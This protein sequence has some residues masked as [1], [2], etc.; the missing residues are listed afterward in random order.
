M[1][2]PE[3]DVT[4]MVMQDSLTVGGAEEICDG[5]VCHWQAAIRVM[6][7]LSFRMSLPESDLESHS[8]IVSLIQIQD[9]EGIIDGLAGFVAQTLED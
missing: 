3:L 6:P 8:Y 2:T 7:D 4:S 5:Y 1:D 9:T